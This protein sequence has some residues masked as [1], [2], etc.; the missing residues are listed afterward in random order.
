MAP[1]LVLKSYYFAGL[2]DLHKGITLGRLREGALAGLLTETTLAAD[3]TLINSRQVSR[4]TTGSLT[5]SSS[6]ASSVGLASIKTR[7]T[8]DGLASIK[9]RA[10]MD[11]LTSIS[12]KT[13]GGLWDVM[14]DPHAGEDNFR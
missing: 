13:W 6:R 14:G 11:G 9:T 1:R 7:A 12:G 10:T 5:N 2:V 8:M 3:Q 4:A